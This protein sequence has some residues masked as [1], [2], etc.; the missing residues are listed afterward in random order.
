MRNKYQ[1]QQL[2]RIDTELIDCVSMT[3]NI[4]VN[5]GQKKNREFCVHRASVN[6]SMSEA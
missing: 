4:L 1:Q 3:F 2:V 5:R 6:V